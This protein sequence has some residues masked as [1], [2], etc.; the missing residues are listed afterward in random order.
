MPREQDKFKDRPPLPED[1]ITPPGKKDQPRVTP[2]TTAQPAD[3][4][5]RSL[6]EFSRLSQ[7]IFS[8]T[9]NYMN[10]LQQ[11]GFSQAETQADVRQEQFR[12]NLSERKKDVDLQQQLSEMGLSQLPGRGDFLFQ[13][14][15]GGAGTGIS[16]FLQSR[17]QQSLFQNL[18]PQGGGL[19]PGQQTFNP[20]QGFG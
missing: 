7:N 2:T 8:T 4:F 6:S 20:F 12:R 18:F 1:K 3:F 14:L 15:L 13:S 5:N 19:Q 16:N 9:N 17:A 10:M 11:L